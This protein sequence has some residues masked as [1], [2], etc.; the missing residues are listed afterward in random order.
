MATMI[1]SHFFQQM[2]SYKNH[3]QMIIDKISIVLLNQSSKRDFT[4]KFISIHQ[5]E[6]ENKGKEIS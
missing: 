4:I 1:I 6:N 3:H 5:T 2:A